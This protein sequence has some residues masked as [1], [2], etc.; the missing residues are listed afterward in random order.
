VEHSTLIEEFSIVGMPKEN[1]LDLLGYIQEDYSGFPIVNPVNMVTDTVMLGDISVD[2][3]AIYYALF[4]TDEIL[5]NEKLDYYSIQSIIG[6]DEYSYQKLHEFQN[7]IFSNGISNK[8][9]VLEYLDFTN[10]YQYNLDFFK[11]VL[12]IE[13]EDLTFNLD[14]D[15]RIYQTKKIFYYEDFDLENTLSGVYKKSEIIDVDNYYLKSEE[16]NDF[17]FM[18]KIEEEELDNFTDNIE[19]NQEYIISGCYLQLFTHTKDTKLFSVF[20]E[21]YYP[22]KNKF[23]FEYQSNYTRP[24]LR[25]TVVFDYW[26]QEKMLIAS[27]VSSFKIS[28]EA[29]YHRNDFN[30]EIS[31][32]DQENICV[33]IVEKYPTKYYINLQDFW[34]YSRNNYFH[35]LGDNN[36]FNTKYLKVVDYYDDY[37][38]ELKKGNLELI[39]DELG[40]LVFEDQVIFT[41][42]F[43]VSEMDHY[44]K[45]IFPYLVWG[46]TEKDR[47][48][49][50]AYA[51]MIWDKDRFTSSKTGRKLTGTSLINYFEG[52]SFIQ[53][54]GSKIPKV[55][56][57]N[58]IDNYYYNIL[59]SENEINE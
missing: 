16:C 57:N 42:N 55:I 3:E 29:H 40:D 22:H 17:N 4:K 50:T 33:P 24:Y 20:D 32:D 15:N 27:E 26:N 10:Q 34:L 48:E 47:I 37:E 41:Y 35:Q 30:C 36:A 54:I 6:G 2:T 43:G 14:Y 56:S 44:V 7:F 11:D 53:N 46:N 19:S 45:D 13:Y 1:I 52:K 58:E 39:F 38:N 31:E 8:E 12:L 18:K 21:E 51:R 5:L 9:K 25:T 59:E 28:K 49:N 23:V